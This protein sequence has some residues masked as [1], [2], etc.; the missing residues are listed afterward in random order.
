MPSRISKFSIYRNF[1]RNADQ[2]LG[3]KLN[4]LVTAVPSLPI[5]SYFIC[6]LG[7]GGSAV[8]NE[9]PRRRQS[10]KTD[11]GEDHICINTSASVL[12]QKLEGW[13]CLAGESRITCSSG[14]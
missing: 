4:I 2:I 11:E 14:T 12:C 13:E 8:L 3:C 9:V 5:P 7:N 10:S 6:Y 1:Y